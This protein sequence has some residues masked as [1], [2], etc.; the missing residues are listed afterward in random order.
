MWRQAKRRDEREGS[1]SP[2]RPGSRGFVVFRRLTT[3]A[4]L[5]CMSICFSACAGGGATSGAQPLQATGSS[6]QGRTTISILIP[7]AASGA[8]AS[9]AR[10][11]QFVSPSTN[12]ASIVA[13]T[14]PRSAH[15]TP[16]ATAIVDLSAG[17]SACTTTSGGARAC[18]ASVGLLGGTDDFTFTTYDR[19]PVAGSFAGA[20]V[21]GSATLRA[22]VIASGVANTVNVALGG[23]VATIVLGPAPLFVDQTAPSSTPLTVTALDADGNTILAGMTTVTNGG[24][25][26]TDTYATPIAIAATETGAT[27]HAKFSLNGAAATSTVTLLRSSD[28]VALVYDGKAGSGSYALSVAASA[29]GAAPATLAVD[30]VPASVTIPLAIQQTTVDGSLGQGTHAPLVTVSVGGGPSVPVLLDTGSSGLRIF[31]DKAGTA[32][33]TGTANQDSFASGLTYFGTVAMANA[34]IGGVVLPSPVPV[35]IVS[36]VCPTSAGALLFDGTCGNGMP[37]E[38]PLIERAGTYGILGVR[39]DPASAT[40]G[41]Y[42]PLGHLPFNLRSGF[43]VALGAGTSPTLTFGLTKANTA[44]F[45]TTDALGTATFPDGTPAFAT[46][47]VPFCYAFTGPGSPNPQP[48]ACLGATDPIPGALSDTGSSALSLSFAQAKPAGIET[49]GYAITATVPG[50]SLTWTFTLAA[51]SKACNG[52]DAGKIA[53]GV[54]S[55]TVET[56]GA[57]PFYRNDVLFDPKDGLF[58]Y[59]PANATPPAFCS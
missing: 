16:L 14:S 58:G 8:S 4:A 28:T 17:S 20:N 21:L 10:R 24:A 47:E 48:S 36:E 38:S 7:P 35:Q 46:S 1:V 44:G 37:S 32:A 12:G 27:G 15:P 56:Q 3:F 5:C 33:S 23:V 9:A 51:P 18:T 52:W 19:A 53:F 41:V 34:T 26:S 55:P 43:I 25:T 30:V 45:A 54:K 11:P 59:R 22:T 49:T 31:A 39:A 50:S 42:S 29:T 57:L 6:A 40:N 13:Y 2:V